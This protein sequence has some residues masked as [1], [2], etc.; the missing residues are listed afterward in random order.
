[1]TMPKLG[2]PSLFMGGAFAFVFNERGEFLILRENDR[3]R[4]YDWDLPGG[5]LDDEEP[6]IEG[7]HREVYE[8]TGLTIRLL[9]PSCFLKWD[10]HES[11]YPILVAFYLSEPT[12][13]TVC[14]SNEHI[15]Y[16]WITRERLKADAIKLPPSE[17]MLDAI[18]H[19]YD[20]IHSHD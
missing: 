4:K 14:L 12:S 19:L 17:E 2:R 11:N 7:L 15:S 3:A 5:T 9:T 20:V 13:D 6:P 8:E 16:Q 10:R 18:F 1:M